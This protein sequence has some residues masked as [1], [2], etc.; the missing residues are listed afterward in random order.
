MKIQ[1]PFFYDY[2]FPNVVLP[3]AL[4]P[5]MGVIN[6]IHTMYSNRLNTVSFFEED[7]DHSHSPF[8]KMF[9]DT[10]GDMPNSLRMG[11]SFLRSNCYKDRWDIQENSVYFGK[12][13]LLG[14]WEPWRGYIYPIKLTFHFSKFTGRDKVGSKLN[15]EYF[16]KH[17][18]AE[19]LADVKSGLAII[20][21]DWS[22]ENF[23]DRSQYIDLHHGIRLSGIPKDRI[24]LAVNSFNAQEVYE[25]W[26]QPH[27]RCLEVR[28]LPFLLSNISYHYS[29]VL[30]GRVSDR[31]FDS[32]KNTIRKNYFVFPN[33][34]S[35][36]HRIAI[37]CKLA[38]EDILDKGDWSCLDP[39]SVDA[40][41]NATT[42][43][44]FTNI[45]SDKVI[46][47]QRS[48]P[49][50]LQDEPEKN[51]HT[52]AGWNDRHSLHNQNSYLYI[53]SETYIQSEYKSLTE[54]V[55]KPLANFQ[56]F[57][58]I[59]FPKALA[60]LRSIGFKTFHPYIDESYDNEQDSIKRMNLIAEEIKRLCSMSKEEM[61]NWYWSMED[62]LRY[63]RQR[64]LEIYK[65]E[66]HSLNLVQYLYDR[67]G[68]DR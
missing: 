31:D 62:I 63:N 16:W 5:E 1:L 56:P 67:I 57:I 65:D 29:H 48:M 50:T 4:A 19:V 44:Q 33:R 51:Y 43:F 46:A 10:L 32:S 25:S 9:G 45:N 17:I 14:G 36:D 39:V 26:F 11:G 37:L 66:Q 53:A 41:F 24:V 59:A 34:R 8:K 47:L 58:F 21:L 13:R 27:E 55:F 49:H 12:E 3:N 54:K 42:Q 40:C 15:G 64:L 35:R 7:L 38:S 20:F 52:A 68:G 30:D 22:N 61:H 2:V 60:E 23:I 28:N 6:Y 18:S